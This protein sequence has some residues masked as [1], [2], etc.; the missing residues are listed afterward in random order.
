MKENIFMCITI[1]L[2]YSRNQ[3]NIV[4]QLYFDKKEK[5]IKPKDGLPFS[6]SLLSQQSQWRS[7]VHVIRA[8]LKKLFNPLI[9]YTLFT[10]CLKYDGGDK[11]R[12]LEMITKVDF[13]YISN[14]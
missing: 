14:E 3:H 11:M 6:F 1:T 2:L 7:E 10:M 12:A 4:N 5:N 8:S 9:T 13:K